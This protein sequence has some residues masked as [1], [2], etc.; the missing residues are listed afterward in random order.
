M[1]PDVFIVFIEKKKIFEYS[2]NVLV[3]HFSYLEDIRPYL[4][5]KL[6]EILYHKD[7]RIGYAAGKCLIEILVGENTDEITMLLYI[8]KVAMKYVS[9]FRT[10]ILTLYV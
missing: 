9:C 5:E 4:F 6:M 10:V 7:H 2:S 3:S 8:C 1:R